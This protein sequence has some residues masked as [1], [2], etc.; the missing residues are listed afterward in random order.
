MKITH[1]DIRPLLPATAMEIADKL[2]PLMAP[3]RHWAHFYERVSSRLREGYKRGIYQR[4]RKGAAAWLYR[5]PGPEY[6][7][8]YDI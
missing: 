8:N 2:H 3:D 6:V 7:E 4:S 5:R 1:D